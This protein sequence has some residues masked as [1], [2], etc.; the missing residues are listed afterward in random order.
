VHAINTHER[1]MPEKKQEVKN[2]FLFTPLL[3][4]CS[5]SVLILDVYRFALVSCFACTLISTVVSLF[6]FFML[7]LSISG[8]FSGCGAP[9]Q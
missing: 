3:R 9:V 6:G 5:R 4:F 7:L 8:V 1:P 2:H